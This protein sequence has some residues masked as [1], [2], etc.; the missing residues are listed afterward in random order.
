M[1]AILAGA[2]ATGLYSIPSRLAGFVTVLTSSLSGVLAPRLAGFGNK[3]EEKKYIIKATLA[4]LPIIAA[5]VFWIIIAKPFILILFGNNYL[6]SVPI[7][8]AL[9]VAMIPF[10][11]TA[12]SVTAIVYAMKKNVYIGAFSF[13]QIAAIFLLNLVFIPKYGPMGPT[14]TF[15]ITNT[16]L[17]IYTWVIV[18]RYYWFEEK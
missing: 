2:T 7:F 11:F 5:L 12:P 9:V 10:V 17:A 15:G 16:I 3:E 14:I 1:L 6:D 13:F 4:T 8:K 18:I